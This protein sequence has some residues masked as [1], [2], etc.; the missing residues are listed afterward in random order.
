MTWIIPQFQL[1]LNHFRFYANPKQVVN[2]RYLQ[3]TTVILM[4]SE[5]KVAERKSNEGKFDD[6]FLNNVWRLDTRKWECFII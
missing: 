4:R 3:Y 6:N 5:V 1:W 2:A